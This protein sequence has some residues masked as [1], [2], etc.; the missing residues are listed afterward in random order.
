MDLSVK[1][2]WYIDSRQD[3]SGFLPKD[4]SFQSDA[5]GQL[6]WQN[7]GGIFWILFVGTILGLG[8]FVVEYLKVQNQI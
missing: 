8:L 3:Y 5:N 4:I 1:L 2:N 7:I 6:D